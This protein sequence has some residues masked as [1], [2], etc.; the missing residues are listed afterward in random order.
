M[1]YLTCERVGATILGWFATKSLEYLGHDLS[2][3]AGQPLQRLV[4]AVQEFSRPKDAVE[5]KRPVKWVL[6]LKPLLIYP[7]FTLPFRVAAD[8]STVGRVACFMP[9]HGQSLQPVVYASKVNSVAESKYVITNLECLAVVWTIKPF[10]PYLPYN[11]VQPSDESQALTRDGSQSK[12]MI[13]S[14]PTVGSRKT[15]S[16][17]KSVNRWVQSKDQCAESSNDEQVRT[18][19]GDGVATLMVV[20]SDQVDAT[21]RLGAVPERVTLTR[22]RTKG[23][24]RL[25]REAKSRTMGGRCE[26][27]CRDNVKEQATSMEGKSFGDLRSRARAKPRYV[28]ERAQ[29]YDEL[30]AAN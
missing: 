3:D 26:L 5:A 23:R 21:S 28:G 6:T 27:Q 16:L 1:G 25:A 9:D 4:S 15:R 12:N 30:W 19:A 18:A 17:D 20:L 22:M 8:A 7:N 10:R 24:F 29:E 14:Y 11:D 2:R 13:A